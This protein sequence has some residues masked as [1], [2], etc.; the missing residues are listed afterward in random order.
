MK[1]VDR[2]VEDGARG[3][4]RRT[5]RR[6][7]LGRLGLILA[8]AATLPLLPMARGAPA[9]PKRPRIQVIRPVATIGA[10]ARLTDFS[11]AAAAAPNTA[12]PPAP[13]RRP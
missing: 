10:T 13:S 7:V 1:R 9:R 8:G 6:S 5:S 12:V 3:L 4:A 11:A 2:W